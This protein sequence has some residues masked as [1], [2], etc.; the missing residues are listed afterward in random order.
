VFSM[1]SILI[2]L[3]LSLFDIYICHLVVIQTM[4]NNVCYE[5]ACFVHD[6]D[7]RIFS[8]IPLSFFMIIIRILQKII[9]ENII[10]SK[11]YYK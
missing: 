2:L 4:L 9:C 3:F 5:F 8:L 6:A 11:C 1:L 7:I 10:N